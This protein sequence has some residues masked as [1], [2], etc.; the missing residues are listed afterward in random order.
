MP[1]EYDGE[2]GSLQSL[3][4]E[5]EKKILSYRN[6]FLDDTDKFGVDEKKRIGPASN[7]LFGIEGSFKRLQFD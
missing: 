2:A 7:P 4:D 6:Y 5:W 3:I 1:I